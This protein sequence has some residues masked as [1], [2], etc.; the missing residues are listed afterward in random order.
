MLNR[1]ITENRNGHLLKQKLGDAYLDF[2]LSRQ[3]ML[4]KESTLEFYKFTTG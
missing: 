2:I 3:A 1:Q 4:C